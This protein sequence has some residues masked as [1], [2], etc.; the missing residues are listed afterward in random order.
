[1]LS[2]NFKKL[3]QYFHLQTYQ[4]KS[5]CGLDIDSSLGWEFANIYQKTP[6]Y[7]NYEA[8]SEFDVLVYESSHS[9][10]YDEKKSYLALKEEFKDDSVTFGDS[11]YTEYG[12]ITTDH[13]LYF[14]EFPERIKNCLVEKKIE[15]H[16]LFASL[17]SSGFITRYFPIREVNEDILDNYNDDLPIDK[18]KEFVEMDKSG[19]AIMNGMPGTGKT[20]LLRKL[21]ADYPYKNFIW[22]DQSLLNQ[23]ISDDFVKFILDRKD[24]IL[25]LEDCEMLVQSRDNCQNN[26][27]N[28]VLNIADGIIGDSLRIKF[29]CTFNT[30][31]TNV[32]KALLR[33]GRLKIKYEFKKLTKDKVANLFNKF[34]IKD[35]PKEMALCDIY[36]YDEVNGGEN[37]RVKIGF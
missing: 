33:K 14:D 36:N 9:K 23:A 12:V 3:I 18:F 2:E 8:S 35:T 26:L 13:I 19:L 25:I 24:S 27:L 1:M 22:F 15:K 11:I 10:N 20:F 28:T 30:D 7:F 34:G 17:G 21:I 31:L 29:I 16:F 37:K 5:L 4:D 32:D 6:K